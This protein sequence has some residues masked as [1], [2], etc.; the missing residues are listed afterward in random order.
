MH[1]LGLDESEEETVI[2][3]DL[4]IDQLVLKHDEVT[5][6][7]PFVGGFILVGFPETQD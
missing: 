4:S 1:E 6:K 3:E 2:L 5:G 7:A